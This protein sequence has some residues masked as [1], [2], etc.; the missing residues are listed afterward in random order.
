MKKKNRQE[1]PIF[2]MRWLIRCTVKNSCDFNVEVQQYITL[3][4]MLQVTL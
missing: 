2:I 1:R 3:Q 4:S